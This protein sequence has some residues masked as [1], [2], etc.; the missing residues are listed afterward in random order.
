M[1]DDTIKGSFWAT[2]YLYKYIYVKKT[3]VNYCLTIFSLM[4]VL[5][6]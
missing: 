1:V 3:N 4:I 5:S 6:D 2:L